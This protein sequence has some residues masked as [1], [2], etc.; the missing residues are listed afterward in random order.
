[1]CDKM[2]CWDRQQKGIILNDFLYLYNVLEDSNT[3][4]S[5]LKTALSKY[6]IR[7]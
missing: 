5:I 4:H 7:K 1:M 3:T 6:S 2:L